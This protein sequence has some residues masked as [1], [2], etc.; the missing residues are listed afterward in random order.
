MNTTHE[1][2]DNYIC[3]MHPIRINI[4]DIDKTISYM[5]FEKQ[6]WATVITHVQTG[7]K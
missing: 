1:P 2:D 3:F 5:E 7:K 4:H 6:A